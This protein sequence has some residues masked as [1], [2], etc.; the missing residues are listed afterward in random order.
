MRT[1]GNPASYREK[2]RITPGYVVLVVFLFLLVF[3]NIFPLFWMVG[4]AFKLP[5]ELFSNRISFF[6]EHPTLDNF[7][8]VFEKYDF[9]DWLRNSAISTILIG[10]GQILIG[11]LA[12]FGLVYFKT[13]WNKA[14]FLT[15]MA[16]MVI[17]FQVTMIPNYILVSKFHLLNTLTAVVV[18]PLASASAFFFVYQHFR[19][20]PA[21]YYEAAR[22]EGAS[23]FWIFHRV[24]VPLCKSSISSMFILCCIDGWNQYFWPLLVLT[25]SKKQTL[26]IGLQQFLDFEMGNNWGPFM[27]TST[28][29]SLPIILIYLFMQRNIIDAFM[30]SGIKG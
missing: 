28:L 13:K 24:V 11:V 26:T 16:T 25:S 3:C 12:A 2:K 1:N 15:L 7:R 18:P 5:A 10:F 30:S 22:V 20:V 19:G 27:A 29:A 23:S 17:P 14:V 9:F 4:S 6:P 8:I 21:T